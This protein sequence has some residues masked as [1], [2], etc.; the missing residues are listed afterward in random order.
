MRY[1]SNP[2][3]NL[4]SHC[5]TQDGHG[6]HAEEHREEMRQITQQEIQ[7]TIPQIQQEAYAQALNSILSSLQADINT[8]VDISFSTGEEIFHDSKTKQIVMKAIY[9]KVIENLNKTYHIK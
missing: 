1:I 8:I 2:S 6:G 7:K 9:K 5:D 3:G 4:M